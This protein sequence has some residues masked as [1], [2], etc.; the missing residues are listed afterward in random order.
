[1]TATRA[2]MAG[3][4]EQ[5]G[6][7][8]FHRRSYFGLLILPLLVIALWYPG[9]PAGHWSDAQFRLVGLLGLAISVTGMVLRWITAGTLPENT[10]RRSTRE[11]RA[12]TLNTTGMYSMVRHPLYLANTII[13]SGFVVAVGSL[14]FLVVFQL[15]HALYL[16]RVMAAEDRFLAARHGASWQEWAMRTPTLIPSMGRPWRGNRLGFSARTV[17]RREYNGVFGVALAFCLLSM[18]RA[19]A[20]DRWSFEQWAMQE[21]LWWWLLLVAALAFVTLRTLKRHTRLLHVRGR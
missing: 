21:R 1:M 4:I 9:M 16:E 6:Q 17:L 8:L 13:V 18:A 20:V 11:L 2:G 3:Q 7:W 5:Q 19:L 14:W 15:A 10:S 12:D